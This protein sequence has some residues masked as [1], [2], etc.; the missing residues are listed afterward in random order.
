MKKALNTLWALFRLRVSGVTMYRLSFF[1][2]FFVDCSVF[3]TQLVF[4]ELLSAGGGADWSREQY[5][6]FIGSF[7][8]LDGA[9]MVTWFFGVVSLPDRIR[10]G[11]LDLALVKPINPLMYLSFCSID[12]GSFPIM[13][14][15]LIVTL[16]AASRAGCL[17]IAN[18]LLWLGA[19]TL[20]YILMY[21]LSLIVRVVSFWT[22]SVGALGAVEGTLVDSAMRL[23]LPAIQGVSKMVLL[24]ALPYGLV[25][26]FPALALAGRS[27]PLWWLY[28]GLLTAAFLIL[29]LFLWRKGLKRYE[30]ASS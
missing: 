28:A 11:E 15:G 5:A 9:Y 3:L 2:G 24:L 6:M 19:M 17:T 21:A 16:S 30:S 29:A 7:M 23:P 8:T 13:I 10:S 18:G 25:G 12:L 26:N 4:L 1:T 20:M 27:T 22:K 14:V